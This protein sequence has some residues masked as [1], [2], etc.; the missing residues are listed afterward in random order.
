ML[1]SNSG[2]VETFKCLFLLVKEQNV[3]SVAVAINALRSESKN[4]RVL[5]CDIDNYLSSVSHLV[6][7]S[8]SYEI[9]AL[10]QCKQ[11]FDFESSIL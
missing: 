8:V 2:E 5:V 7:D 3:S 6:F 4:V 11:L 1:S 10:F 9:G